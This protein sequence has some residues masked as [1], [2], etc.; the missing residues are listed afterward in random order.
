MGNKWHTQVGKFENCLQMYVGCVGKPHSQEQSP[1]TG[2]VR[3]WLQIQKEQEAVDLEPR[4]SKWRSL[5]DR[6]VTLGEGHSQLMMV[7][8]GGSWRNKYLK[9]ALLSL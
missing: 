4:V 2:D 8:Q 9:L 3:E 5:S 7:P 1:G 6:A